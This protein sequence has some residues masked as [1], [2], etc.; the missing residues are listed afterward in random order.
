[1]I[2]IHITKSCTSVELLLDF[3]FDVCLGVVVVKASDLELEGSADEFVDAGPD[4]DVDVTP[5][6]VVKASEL[7]LDVA[8]DEAVEESSDFDVVVT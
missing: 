4:F 3:E 7:E 1:M 6:D 5:K 8:A 2:E